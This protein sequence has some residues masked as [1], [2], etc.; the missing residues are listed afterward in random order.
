M[1][2][3]Q[4]E[5]RYDAL[6]NR[7]CVGLGFCGCVR[8]ERSIHVSMFIPSSGPVSADQFVEWVFLADDMNPNVDCEKWAPLKAQV[9]EA[10]VSHMGGEVVDAE[11]LQDR[12]WRDPT[13]S[14]E[15]AYGFHPRK[16]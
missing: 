2:M 4:L 9:R 7:I 8:R 13:L 5:D 12:V 15:R 3:P 1:V 10:F 16:A 14:V 11:L 6:M